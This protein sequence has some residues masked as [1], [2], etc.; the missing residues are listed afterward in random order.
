MPSTN[1]PTDV[2]TLYDMTQANTECWVWKGAWGGRTTG[3]RPYFMCSGVRTMAYRVVYNLV[4][5]V[6]L[7]PE[8]QLLHS[9]DN[10]AWPIGCGN[11]AHMRVGTVK[12]NANDRVERQRHGMSHS[13]VQ[14]IRRLLKRGETQQDIADLLTISRESV[15]A[16]ATGRTYSQV[17]QEE[18][19]TNE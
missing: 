13:T 16:I 3:K 12:E 11:P 14:L 10:G 7:T 17:P 2:F 5:G 8:M 15:S 1:E 19:H 9:C 6:T 18:E 4:N